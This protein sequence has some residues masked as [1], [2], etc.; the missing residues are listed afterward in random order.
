MVM[1]LIIMQRSLHCWIHIMVRVKVSLLSHGT[2][3][4]KFNW[5]IDNE[6]LIQHVKPSDKLEKPLL[7]PTKITS[8][9]GIR[10]KYPTISC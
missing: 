6:T 10:H 4:H 8:N 5:V 7:P 2:L 3:I 1:I 9:S